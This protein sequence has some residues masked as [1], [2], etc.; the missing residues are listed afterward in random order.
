MKN[1]FYGVFSPTVTAFHEDGSLN[2]RG[3]RDY[4]RFQIEN[5]V[6]GLAPLGSAGEPFVLTNQ[7]R[8]KVME[9]VLDETDGRVPVLAGTG[10]A[11]T[12]ATIELSSHAKKKGASGLL[13]IT[14]YVQRPPREAVLDHFRTV[15]R[16]IKLPLMMYN[17]P[18]VTGV[19]VSPQDL[20]ILYREG[21]LQSAKWSHMEISRIQETMWLCGPKFP[22][23][24]GID[25]LL[26]AG[27]TLGCTGMICGLPMFSPR[28]ARKLFELV[29]EQ[30]NLTEGRA[31]WMKLQPWIQIEYSALF[32]PSRSPHWLSVCRAVAQLRGI[33]V[34]PPRPPLQPLEREFSVQLKKIM[35]DLGEL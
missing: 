13:L 32:S 7:E 11:G 28:L 17:V 20:R 3:T 31:L 5:G 33:K 16:V 10:H 2:E 9:W 29:F 30:H 8:M 26:F 18:I 15:Q 34:G 1:L 12:A 6:H 21:T 19:E 4:V 24:A 27:L 14:P 22:V 35:K 23:F 25:Y